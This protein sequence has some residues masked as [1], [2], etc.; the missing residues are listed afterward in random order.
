MRARI[1]LQFAC[2]ALVV[3]GCGQTTPPPLT[4]AP[5]TSFDGSWASSCVATSGSTSERHVRELTGASASRTTLSYPDATC[6]GIP[7]VT[8]LGGTVASGA[9]VAAAFGGRTVNAR[10]LDFTGDAGSQLFTIAF[11]DT[12][13]TPAVYYEGDLSGANDGSTAA[14]RPTALLVTRA[15]GYQAAV[16]TP[17][18]LAA[19]LQGSWGICVAS[20]ATASTR[21]VRTFAGVGV[22]QSATTYANATCSGPGTVIKNESGAF[23]IRAPATAILGSTTVPGYQYDYTLGPTMNFGLLWIDA[24]AVPQ[25]IHLGDRTGA[26][27]GST[28]AL[29]PT[30]LLTTPWTRQ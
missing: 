9:T 3:S 21:T 7:T 27:N 12:L 13:S 20:S 26:M 24:A 17:A 23:T 19:L 15:Y 11:V 2:A 6:S 30:S 16:Q 22:S 1:L 10:A 5:I 29:R 18:E 8:T 14:L 25:R 28:P 4:T